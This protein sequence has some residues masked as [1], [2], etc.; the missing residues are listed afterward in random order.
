MNVNKTIKFFSWRQSGVVAL[1]FAGLFFGTACN[2]P[3]ADVT[4]ENVLTLTKENFQS[5]VLVSS[6]PVLVDFWATWCGPCKMIAPAVA[7]LATEFKGKAK[8]G[9]VDVDAQTELAREYNIS[10]IP[11]LLIF[12]EGKMVEQIIGLRSKDELK[13]ALSKFVTD[14]PAS[15]ATNNP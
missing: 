11:S 10:A 12:K 4:N 3:G 2:K 1:A 7:E 15:S 8:V 14:N 5:E 13:A 6:Q 9:K